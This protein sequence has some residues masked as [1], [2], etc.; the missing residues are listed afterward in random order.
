[1]AQFQAGSRK[2]LRC[3][4]AVFFVIS[5]VLLVHAKT[6]VPVFLLSG[7]SN[8]TGYAPTSGL[9]TDQMKTV[10]NVKIYM[11]LVWEGDASKL[12]KWL[13]LGPGFGSSSSNIGP[14]LFLGRTLSDS[15]PTTQIALIKCCSGS[16]YLGKA[17][18]WLPPSSNNGTGG[19]LYRK[20]TDTAIVN[21]LK[22]FNTAFDTSKYTPQWAGFIWL[23]GEFDAED[24]TLSN[25]Y[26]TNLTNLI[27]DIRAKLKV[28]DL[29]VVIP[30]IDVQN[31]WTYNSIV[32]AAEVAMTTTYKNA[33]TLDTKGY[34]TNG[35]H[36]TG[37]GQVKIGMV[38]AQRWMHMHYTYDPAVS[39]AAATPAL[40][41]EPVIAPYT[42]SG[43]FN[44][45]GR[46][47]GYAKGSLESMPG[48]F[49]MASKQSASA[50][51]GLWMAG[52]K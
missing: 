26:K 52:D 39:I 48:V 42:A 14:E 20:M 4:Q 15:F 12:R 11:D 9:T 49:I 1:M 29:P 50:R 23:Q 27:K 7:Q 5:C 31:Q 18:D 35:T 34:P 28:T 8:M 47:I 24:L 19:N 25:A 10:P 41:R 37:P 32:R 21:A 36:Y 3:G 46:R 13:T 2:T 17:S 33:D 40:R 16:T 51:T 43:L 6:A 22:T 45:S 44:V 30:M 38:T